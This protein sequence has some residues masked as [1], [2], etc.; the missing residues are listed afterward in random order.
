VKIYRTKAKK[1]TGTDYKEI[2]HKAL[3][4][5]ALIRAK[6]KRRPYVRSAYFSKEKIFLGLFWSHLYKKN[7]RDQRRR[8]K[9]FNCAIELIKK[10]KCDPDSRE[11]PNRREELLHKFFGISPDNEL[12]IVQIKE[13]KRNNQK[14]LI[15]IFPKE[16]WE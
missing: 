7:Y 5:Y 16:K 1:L 6:S 2:R 14:W 13:N 12:F 11:N 9:L 8:M 15:S 4:S 3:S 10:S